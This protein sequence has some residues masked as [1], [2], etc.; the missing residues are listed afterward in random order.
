[1]FPDLF[2]TLYTTLS[3]LIGPHGPAVAAKAQSF[4]PGDHSIYGRRAR[5]SGE[6]AQLAV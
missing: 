5:E 6:L 2:D 3:T 4:A 1:M